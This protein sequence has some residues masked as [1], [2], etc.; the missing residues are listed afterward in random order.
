AVADYDRDG[1][2][3]LLVTGWGR[4]ALYHNVPVDERDPARG[5]KF[6][7][8]SDKAGLPRGLWTTS[9]AWGD[10]DGDGW[11]ALYLCQ[12]VDWALPHNH[13]TDCSY[14]G[15]TR[16]VCPPRKFRPLPHKLFHNDHG[17]FTDVSK[18]AGLRPD[19][20][21]L[22]VLLVDVNGDGRPDVYVA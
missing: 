7:E 6:V 21:G 11:P 4:L 12:Y 15:R 3:D 14:D 5:R 19:G 18:E 2:P 22:G 10:L 1:W 20:R 17:T 9:A 16:D 13:P 8:V